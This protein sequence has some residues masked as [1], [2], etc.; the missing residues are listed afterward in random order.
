MTWQQKAFRLSLWRCEHAGR[1]ATRT[2]PHHERGVSHSWATTGAQSPSVPANRPEGLCVPPSD[3][4][5][6]G[7]HQAA[8][9][10]VGT[11]LP[12]C[13]GLARSGAQPSLSPGT[14]GRP[15][16]TVLFPDPCLLLAPQ[17]QPRAE[18]QSERPAGTLRPQQR[19]HRAPR[20]PV[21]H[22]PTRSLPNEHKA[23]STPSQSEARRQ[24]GALAG[25]RGIT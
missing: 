10:H 11:R 7:A 12:C 19:P 21:P 24:A 2:F 14:S 6:G 15:P 5:L 25:H 20:Q 18:G 17:G 22:L 1:Q 3:H 4:T 13:A 23:Q 9:L 16:L 8:L